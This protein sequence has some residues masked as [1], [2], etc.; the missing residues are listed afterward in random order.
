MTNDMLKRLDVPAKKVSIRKGKGSRGYNKF[1]RD[2]DGIVSIDE[3]YLQS[4]D[5]RAVEYQT[6]T[7]FHEAYHAKA[8]GSTIDYGQR[9]DGFSWTDIEETFAETSSHYA[10]QALGIEKKLSPAYPQILVDT[11]PRLKQLEKYQNASSLADF[12]K[13]AWKDRLD[14]TPSMWQ[15]LA[16]ELDGIDHDWQT[17]GLQYE[18]YINSNKDAMFSNF[19][20][21][22]PRNNDPQTIETMKEELASAFEKTRNGQPLNA[23]ENWVYTG[24]L[25]TAMN[26][27][28]VW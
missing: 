15:G 5:D 26:Q 13:I 21:N 16:K 11:L 23:N 19:I 20:E 24:V 14:G 7:M 8:S 12:G 27:T 22:S 4:D 25:A 2:K 10:V 17:Y 9:F 3:F 18:P 6:K 28:G 1:A